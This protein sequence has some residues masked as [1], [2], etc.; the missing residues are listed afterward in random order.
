MKYADK[1]SRKLDSETPLDDVGAYALDR[2]AEYLAL[3]ISKMTEVTNSAHDVLGEREVSSGLEVDY[4]LLMAEDVFLEQ[5]LPEPDESRDGARFSLRWLMRLHLHQIK[6]ELSL[7]DSE[8][9]D[10]VDITI[11]IF[12]SHVGPCWESRLMWY[13]GREVMGIGRQESREQSKVLIVSIFDPVDCGMCAEAVMKCLYTEADVNYTSD[14][15]FLE[16]YMVKYLCFDKGPSIKDEY[17]RLSQN[18]CSD[19]VG[20]LLGGR[21]KNKFIIGDYF[22]DLSH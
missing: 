4:A 5:H 16:L 10:L 2:C 7:G 1:V 15:C 19:F 13:K 9:V 20:M 21:L 11:D 12:E 18:S 3:P 17:T 22:T 8:R 14:S 6:S